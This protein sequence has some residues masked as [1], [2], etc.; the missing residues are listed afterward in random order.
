MNISHD[1]GYT[2]LIV[3]AQ[4]GHVDC[5]KSFYKTGVNIDTTGKDGITA[6]IVQ[7]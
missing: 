5:F 7:Q 1:N 6:L 4:C 2:S 3:T